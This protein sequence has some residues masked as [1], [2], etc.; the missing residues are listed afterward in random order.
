MVIKVT[1]FQLDD[2]VCLILKMVCSM[3]DKIYQPN[4]HGGHL[5]LVLT[6]VEFFSIF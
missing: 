5:K 6:E 1:M 4:Y 3:M 2:Q